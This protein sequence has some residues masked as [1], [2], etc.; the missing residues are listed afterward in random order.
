MTEYCCRFRRRKFRSGQKIR[1]NPYAKAPWV[2]SGW[3]REP[4]KADSPDFL[5]AVLPK[6][7]RLADNDPNNDFDAPTIVA[8]GT[9][10]EFE[11]NAAK[12]S[13]AYVST[14]SKTNMFSN[15]LTDDVELP[16]SAV[17]FYTQISG[18]S[19]ATPHV[20]GVVAL[21]LDADPTL[22][23]D[24]IKQILIDTASRMP[25]YEEFQVGAGYVNAYAAVDKVFKPRENLRHIQHAAI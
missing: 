9:G 23:A 24:E 7:E 20:A 2:I 25:G 16:V 8:P 14:R 10:R 5:R 21:M 6:E 19:M 12:Y 22:S 1:T 11:A 13:A 17:P 3:L 15:G 4:K 18:T